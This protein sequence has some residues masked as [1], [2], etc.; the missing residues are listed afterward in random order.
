LVWILSMKEIWL[1]SGVAIKR[2][3]QSDVGL[4]SH[5]VVLSVPTLRQTEK[6]I[7][8]KCIVLYVTFQVISSHMTD[9]S[10]RKTMAT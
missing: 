6:A 9:L 4:S 2:G 7:D 5:L 3:R 10:P 8:C 1:H